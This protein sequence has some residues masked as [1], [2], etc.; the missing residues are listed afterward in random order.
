MNID[1]LK[2]LVLYIA[3]ME[4]FGTSIKQ[5]Y[6][7]RLINR[8]KQWP[9]CHTDKL[10][11]LELVKREK[12]EGYSAKQQRGKQDRYGGREGKAV[13]RTPLAYGD[14]FKV[15]S[16]KRPVRKVLVEG[17]A[18]IGKT[19]LCI[20]V[21][22]D[23]ANGKLFQQFELVLHLPLRTKAVASA[24]SLPQLLRLLHSCEDVCDSVASYL[25]KTEG[26]NVLIIADGWDE[27]SES[28]RQRD[29]FLYQLLFEI[30]SFISVIVT[31]RPSAS[32]S[33]HRLSYID[34]LVEVQ[35]F[36]R[37]NI[38]EY[39]NYEFTNNQRKATSLLEQLEYN[40]LVE[41]V[42]SVPLNCAIV[43][44]L[45]RT[46]EEAL[47]TTMTELYTKIILNVIL[48]NIQKK[49]EFKH[50]D[51]LPNF[52]ALPNE[53]QQSWT[54]LCKFALISIIKDHIV[55]SQE[56]L[57]NIF[58]RGLA[59]DIVHCFG[60]LQTD[61]TVL[62]TGYGTSFHFLHLTFQEYLAALHLAKNTVVLDETFKFYSEQRHFAIVWRFFF[63]I[64]FNE[65]ECK[66]VAPIKPYLSYIHNTL[67]CCHCAFEARNVVVASDIIS[68][69]KRRHYR[70]DPSPNTAH[71]CAAVIYVIDKMQADRTLLL[72]FLKCHIGEKQIKTLTDSLANKPGKLQ[73]EELHLDARKLSYVSLG[74][75]LDKASSAFQSLQSLSLKIECEKALLARLSFQA[76]Q[77][78][79]LSGSNLGVS[80]I[81][82]LEKA[83]SDGRLA[84]LQWLYLSGCCIDDA[85]TNGGALKKFL[86]SLSDHCPKLY[87]LDL[88]DNDLGVLGASALTSAISQHN[89]PLS[90]NPELGIKSPL[91]L[92]SIDLHNTNLGDDGLC[93][94]IENLE[95]PNHFHSLN[96]KSNN[97]HA[98][99]VA[100][101]AAYYN[102]KYEEKEHLCEDISELDLEDNPLG[103]EGVISI[104]EILGGCDY[105]RVCLTKCLLTT[106]TEIT[107]N[108]PSYDKAILSQIPTSYVDFLYLDGNCFTGERIHI[109]AGFIQLCPALKTL[110]CEDCDITSDDLILLLTII[111][112]SKESHPGLCEWLEHWDLSNNEIDDR[113]VSELV[114]HVPSLFPGLFFSDNDD[115]CLDGNPVSSEVVEKL[116]QK[117]RSLRW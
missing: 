35:G 37:E 112:K 56:E 18:G 7:E 105:E 113:G 66:D 45:W 41:S 82:A 31:S 17:D 8:E 101:L 40:P 80:G 2:I 43:C 54:L 88:S 81:Q 100:C 22:E 71:D 58:P 34:R 23:W 106:A 48:R 103:I 25:N 33:L 39:I 73:I 94:F 30:F 46:L 47:P 55:F 60:L 51:S 87:G 98:T 38:K 109:L 92:K 96:L 27:L 24:G 117:L 75:L 70:F 10:V 102:N 3:G 116:K 42:C 69:E 12:G 74:D 104:G 65:L 111:A 28:E 85:D 13:K 32:A 61:K 76:L 115:V 63:G 36:S 67:E 20:A 59:D 72:N 29:S 50:I 4:T 53:L 84:E 95:I 89:N 108:P 6:Q 44:H 62:E 78:L 9:P 19:T 114:H 5:K 83:V 91:W 93:A 1:L 90:L 79:D 107:G 68:L 86:K 57:A 110:Y 64:Y 21:S 97:I 52:N 49:D 11:R 99:G 16:G 26:K 77:H 14:L 15:E